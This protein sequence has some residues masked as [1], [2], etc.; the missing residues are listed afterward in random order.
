MKTTFPIQGCKPLVLLLLLISYSVSGQKIDSTFKS[1]L[2]Q[3]AS[4]A[5]EIVQQPDGKILLAGDIAFFDSKNVGKVVRLNL[6]GSLDKTLQADLPANFIPVNME[7]TSSG[8][9]LLY[10]YS[11]IIKL[12]PNGR[13]KNIIEMNGVASVTPLANDKF[14]VS[15]W[16]G[17][18]YRYKG[19]FSIDSSFPNQDR[20][21][22]GAITDVAIQ[23][24]KLVLC[25]SFTMVRG[26]LK[27]DLARLFLN[28]T[29]D[30]TLI[31]A[32][33]QVIG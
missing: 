28:G 14:M 25:G 19:N 26:V 29:V 18:L 27:N 24:N 10:D 6:D 1:P 31:Q 13:F 4:E 17:G 20:F 21:A 32:S 2:V 33:V 9:I 23:D 22:D 3:R 15:T 7:L 30:N 11:R 5:Y 8:N 12:G 16:S